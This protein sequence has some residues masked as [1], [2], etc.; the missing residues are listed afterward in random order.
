VLAKYPFKYDGGLDV[1]I[2]VGVGMYRVIG[3]YANA[4]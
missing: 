3:K 4:K 2:E 1:K